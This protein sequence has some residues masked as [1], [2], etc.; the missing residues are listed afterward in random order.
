[1]DTAWIRVT[2]LGSNSGFPTYNNNCSYN[3]LSNYYGPG[4]LYILFCLI[5]TSAVQC[6]YYSYFKHRETKTKRG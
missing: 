4:A 6:G 1:M 5:P 2:H 3:L